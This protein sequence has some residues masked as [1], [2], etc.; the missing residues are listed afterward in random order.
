MRGGRDGEIGLELLVDVGEAARKGPDMPIDGERETDR[1]ARR[2]VGILADHEHPHV[3]QGTRERAQHP[4]ARGQISAPRRGLRAQTVTQGRDVGG[5]GSERPRP[6]G[7]HE[8]R[9]RE[10]RQRHRHPV[11]VQCS[12]DAV[13]SSST[14][15]P[16]HDQ[17][18]SIHRGVSFH[19]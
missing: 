6:T 14:T 11:S 2:R 18:K 1:M 19:Q 17:G 16:F 7:V 13:R 10:L 4:V 5:D 12:A 9:L 15:E 3:L 8:A